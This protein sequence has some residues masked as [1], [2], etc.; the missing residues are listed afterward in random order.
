MA[1]FRPRTAVGQLAIYAADIPQNVVTPS[2]NA[3]H[4]SMTRMI[5]I[6]YL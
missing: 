5:V 6:L 2:E 3:K 1:R 4:A